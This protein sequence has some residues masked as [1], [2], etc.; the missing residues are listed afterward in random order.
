MLFA[1]AKYCSRDPGTQGKAAR[2]CG[3][4]K[5][6]NL[7]FLFRSASGPRCP[8]FLMMSWANPFT[9]W[10]FS[11]LSE[12]FSGLKIS[13]I[14][15]QI[16]HHLPNSNL[17]CIW[18]KFEKLEESGAGHIG[19]FA[20]CYLFGSLLHLHW[21]FLR[22]HGGPVMREIGHVLLCTAAWSATECILSAV[23]LLLFRCPAVLLWYFHPE[24]TDKTYTSL[25]SC[26]FP[27]FLRQF[28]F[29]VNFFS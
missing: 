1:W 5:G 3:L 18:C 21:A 12:M 14:L 6:P 29:S 2:T 28:E 17:S 24:V 11:C 20:F 8:F 26:E 13:F 16:P 23:T 19:H 27:F 25:C 10:S 4:L 15:N 22:T 9:L 7:T